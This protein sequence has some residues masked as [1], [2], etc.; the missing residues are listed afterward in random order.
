[1]RVGYYLAISLESEKE[2]FEDEEL[3]LLAEEIWH[4]GCA[5]TS[6][7]IPLTPLEPTTPA[8]PTPPTLNGNSKA[9]TDAGAHTPETRILSPL[10]TAP[11][12]YQVRKLSW[13]W[14]WIEI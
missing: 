6:F 8:A 11:A 4:T 5:E 2:L 9:H 10:L 14:I 1:M 12:H 7:G 13:S 3:S